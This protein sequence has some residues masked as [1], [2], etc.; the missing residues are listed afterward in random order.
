MAHSPQLPELYVCKQCHGVY[1]GTIADGTPEGHKY[2]S[3]TDCAACG[4]T[5]F[6][7]IEQY[8]HFG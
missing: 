7:Q 1:A 8:P 4:G 2:E 5:E 3:P 6:I